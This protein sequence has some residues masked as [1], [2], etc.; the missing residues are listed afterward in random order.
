M[1]HMSLQVKA[2]HL[3]VVTVVYFIMGDIM[4][5]HCKYITM[6]MRSYLI[7]LQHKILFL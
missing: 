6:T 4:S 5:I 1:S 7:K 2:N 3:N